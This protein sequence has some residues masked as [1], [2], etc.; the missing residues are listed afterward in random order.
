[1]R[2]RPTFAPAFVDWLPPELV[3]EMA[4]NGRASWPAVA[5]LLGVAE[6]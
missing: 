5:A 2:A 4:A 3:A 6:R 1:M